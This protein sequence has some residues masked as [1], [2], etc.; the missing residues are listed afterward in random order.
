M[1]GHHSAFG[2]SGGSVKGRRAACA[3]SL[4]LMLLWVMAGC[5]IKPLQTAE[6]S[7][8]SSAQWVESVPDQPVSAVSAT[9]E[10]AVATAGTDAVASPPDGPVT[11]KADEVPANLSPDEGTAASR[12]GV[13]SACPERTLDAALAGTYDFVEISD[14]HDT[15]KSDLGEPVLSVLAANL[16]RID[17]ENPGRTLIL[18]GG[19]NVDG[20]LRVFRD[21]ADA[22]V[23]A[24]LEEMGVDATALG[25]HEYREYGVDRLVKET[26]AQCGIPILCANLLDPATEKPAFAPYRVFRLGALRVAVIGSSSDKIRSRYLDGKN[27]EWR[28]LPHA[29]AINDQARLIRRDDLADLVVALVHEGGYE[30]DKGTGGGTLVKLA[31]ELEGVDAVFGGD[32]HTVVRIALNGMPVVVP[33]S[34]G[35]GF[36]RV[37]LRVG[38][39]GAMQFDVRHVRLNTDAANGYRAALPVRDAAVEAIVQEALAN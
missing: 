5:G 18:S 31:G 6:G 11:S 22:P 15:V 33:G 28:Y 34:E 25:N 1:A 8:R 16:K 32:T 35:S 26:F 30:D 13:T 4:V 29:E 39:D 9:S 7:A 24:A 37:A 36:I 3:L 23:M 20:S 19:D 10:A 21:E 27:P 14:L 17:A 12:S 38:H 2:G